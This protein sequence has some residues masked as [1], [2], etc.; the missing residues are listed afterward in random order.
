MSSTLARTNCRLCSRLSSLLR[1]FFCRVVGLRCRCNAIFKQ[2]DNLRKGRVSA[3]NREAPDCACE[4]WS[5]S[6]YS[7]HP[8]KDS[9]TVTRF[10]FNPRHIRDNGKFKP[11]LFSQVLDE[12]C[13]I[14]RETQATDDELRRF[15]SDVLVNQ[16]DQS[17]VG[18]V[19]ASSKSI[20]AIRIEDARAVCL[21]DTALDANRSHAEMFAART[22]PEA[23]APELRRHLLTA[24]GEGNVTPRDQYRGGAVWNELPATCQR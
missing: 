15:V 7:P 3:I 17:W 12:G 11:S 18:V 16:T 21:Y 6:E 2:V 4:R 20:R 10:V 1:R 9:E 13:S 22:L 24:F 14:Q 5:T 8:I 23:D 19:S